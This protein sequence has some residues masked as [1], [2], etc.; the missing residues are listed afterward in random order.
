MP[1]EFKYKH[2]AGT[3]AQWA[4]PQD[5]PL[6]RGEIGVLLDADGT[7]LDAKIGDGATAFADLPSLGANGTSQEDIDA[8]VTAHVAATDP[9]GDRA[10][11]RRKDPFARYGINPL[12]SMWVALGSVAM[13]SGSL[14]GLYFYADTDEDITELSVIV[15]AAAAATPTL[16]RLGVYVANETTGDLTALAAATANDTAL[17]TSTGLRSGAISSGT[18]VSG[19][20]WTPTI[21]RFYFIGALV[22]TDAAAPTVVSNG[23]LGGEVFKFASPGGSTWVNWMTGKKTGQTDLPASLTG[24]SPSSSR[25]VL[26]VGVQ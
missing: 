6:L 21:G 7:P 4:D 9:H 15:N 18:E 12:P 16:S 26:V 22:V 8:A 14:E 17:F 25:C 20:I 11:T 1:N 3:L 2:R 13:A 19:G 10:F 24:M 23:T 5:G